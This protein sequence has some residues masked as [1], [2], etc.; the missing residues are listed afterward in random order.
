MAIIGDA[1]SVLTT[2]QGLGTVIA[3]RDLR[4]V[5]IKANAGNS[6]TVYVGGTDVTS[7]GANAYIALEAGA[8][9]SAQ[10]SDIEEFK[11]DWA[12]LYVVGSSAADLVHI[13]LIS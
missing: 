11:I 9:W 4:Q 7:A 12:K 6:G 3:R 2:T 1:V 13:A 5:D 10:I 8:Q